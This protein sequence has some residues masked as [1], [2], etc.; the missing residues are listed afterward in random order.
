MMGAQVYRETMLITG[1]L[2]VRNMRSRMNQG[3]INE[4]GNQVSRHAH[5]Q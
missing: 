4:L 3:M 1:D 5:V 2:D